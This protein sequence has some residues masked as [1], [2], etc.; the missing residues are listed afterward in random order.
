M[1]AFTLVETLVAIT[2]VLL[3]VLGP[4]QLVQQSLTSSYIARDQLIATALAE[5]GLEFIRNLRDANYLY[6]LENPTTP[7]Y[8]LYGLNTSAGAEEDC[9]RTQGCTVDPTR[10]AH[11]EAVAECVTTCPVLYLNSS[12][13]QY[14][15]RAL[16]AYT[17]TRFTRKVLLEEVEGS[18]DTKVKV[19][20]TVTYTSVH[21]THTVTVSDYL[22]NWL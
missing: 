3:A 1:K 16:A 13:Q 7:R 18:S 20:V 17:P 4:F 12:T 21:N 9:F 22:Y 10:S 6:N 5:E 8:W 19:T 11:N 15:Q 14:T 2:V